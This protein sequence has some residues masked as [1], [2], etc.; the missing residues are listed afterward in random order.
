MKIYSEQLNKFY[1]TVAECEKA[2]ADYKATVEAARIEQERKA[3]LAKKEKEQKMAKRKEAAAKVDAAR[4]AYLE[5]QHVYREQLEE[6][7]KIYGTYHYS[8]DNVEEIPSLFDWFGNIFK[9]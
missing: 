9:L 1:D 6:F 4:K 7:V 8:T 5:A 3:E 2:E